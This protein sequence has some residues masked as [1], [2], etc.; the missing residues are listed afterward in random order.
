MMR[1]SNTLYKNESTFIDFSTTPKAPQADLARRPSSP[2]ST[3]NRDASLFWFVMLREILRVRLSRSP[4]SFVGRPKAVSKTF[5]TMGA[6]CSV[7][8]ELRL[9]C[10]AL[11][12]WDSST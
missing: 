3:N 10:I 2:F 11:T 12:E 8:V 7:H 4:S 6:Y 9:D 1:D 5:A